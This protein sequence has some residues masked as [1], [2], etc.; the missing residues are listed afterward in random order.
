MVEKT[1]LPVLR[2]LKRTRYRIFGKSGSFDFPIAA[3]ISSIALFQKFCN[4]ARTRTR[5]F[6]PQVCASNEFWK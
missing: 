3:R 6:E 4:K 5:G 2:H 1:G